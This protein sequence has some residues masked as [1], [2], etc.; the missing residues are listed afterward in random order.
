MSAGNRHLA[1]ALGYSLL[2]T[3]GLI[4]LD[5]HNLLSEEFHF[6]GAK[7]LI[8]AQGPDPRLSAI[9]YAFPPLLIYLTMLLGSPITTQ[10]LLVAGLVFWLGWLVAQLP[11]RPLWR[12]VILGMLLFNPAFVVMVLTS[13]TWTAISLF[14]GLSVLLYWQLIQPRDPHYPL[15]VNL[16]LL[17]LTLTPLMLLRYE[18]WWLLPV[19][20]VV[21]WFA[22]KESYIPLKLTVVL[23][24]SFMPIIAV[25]G[26][27]YVNWLIAGDAFYF[28]QAPGN[29]LRWP[30][31]G[32]WLTS[33]PG[34]Q[35]LAES[36]LWLAKTLP[37]YYV[38]AA[39]TL[40][41]GRHRWLPSA[42]L[43]ALPALLLAVMLW[44]G[45][46]LPQLASSGALV[47]LL[48]VMLL[49]GR[50]WQPVQLLPIV[51]VLGLT[52]YS[53]GHL[54]ASADLVP[55]EQ[56]VWQQI[57][58]PRESAGSGV[59]RWQQKQRAQQTI[60]Q[61]LFERLRPD[62]RILL[63]DAVNFSFIYLLHNPHLFVLP[64][65]YEFNLALTQPEE[66]VSYVLLRRGTDLEPS[67]DQLQL[68][69]L[70]L[71]GAFINIASNDFYQLWQRQ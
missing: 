50:Q 47:S 34:W 42:L 12:R 1:L 61:V 68:D 71:G 35:A 30:E 53:S 56:V 69:N 11:C 33:A 9:G 59:R 31:M 40:W 13:P 49:Q 6:L 65:Q 24:I 23:V 58:G 46:F 48:P 3:F 29:G 37:A 62:Q 28:L 43:L 16:V 17:G 8:A 52:L 18:F 4:F 60:V 66:V 57:A 15:S 14:L 55:T 36:L 67:A 10:V 19:L 2:L 7:G 70:P 20:M 51:A 26:F 41:T 5:T 54:L 64:H 25:L 44:Q 38:L 21:S 22:L 32:L 27:L 45:H 39:L 63:D